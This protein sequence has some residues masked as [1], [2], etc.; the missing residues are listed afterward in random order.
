MKLK[1]L[2]SGAWEGIPAPFCNC[3]I[4]ESAKKPNS[5]D[6][7]TRPQILVETEKGQFLIEISPDIAPNPQ[8]LI[9]QILAIF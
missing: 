6:N 4:C 7:R 2:G 5:K 3:K 1:I 8:N 9:C